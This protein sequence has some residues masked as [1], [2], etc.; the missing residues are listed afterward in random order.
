MEIVKIVPGQSYANAV[1]LP[2]NKR[3]ANGTHKAASGNSGA[4]R[5]VMSN[6]VRGIHA[7]QQKADRTLTE[8]S[9]RRLVLRNG[10]KHWVLESDYQAG[11]W[12]WW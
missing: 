8:A 11:T 6:S 4:T 12:Q 5:P 1:E 2:S 9:R 3:Y 10:K 7:E